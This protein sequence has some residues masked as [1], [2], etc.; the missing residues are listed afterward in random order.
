MTTNK[1]ERVGGGL[2]N[3]PLPDLWT[4][5]AVNQGRQKASRSWRSGG[6]GEPQE[7]QWILPQGT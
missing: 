1:S 3:T 5:E 4:R 2:K 7:Q 6:G